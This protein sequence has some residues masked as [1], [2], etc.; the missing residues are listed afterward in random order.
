MFCL[1]LY[2][3]FLIHSSVLGHLGCFH[4]L[5]IV[6]SA[7]MNIGMRVPFQIMV[8]SGY[9]PRSGLAGSYGNSTFSFLRNL[10][11]VFHNGCTNLYSHEQCRRASFSTALV[12]C[13]LFNDDHSDW[14]KVVPH[15]S[16]DLHFPNN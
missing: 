7:A 4:V 13:T 2:Q 8:L 1:Y 6:N 15:Y 12:I 3:I 9:V 10:H 16:F 11:I 5:A 14:C